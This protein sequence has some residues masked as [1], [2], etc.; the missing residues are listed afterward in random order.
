MQS[1]K[2]QV[3]AYFFVVGRLFSA[4][5]HGRP[6]ILET[7]NRRFSTAT[8]LGALVAG[9]LVA[10]FGILGLYLPGT[11]TSWQQPGAI[12]VDK[13]TGARYL[14]LNGRLRP[15]LNYT[16]AR[17]AAGSNAPGTIVQVSA[18]SLAGV[19][20]GTPIGI[21]GAPDSVPAASRLDAGPWTVCVSPPDVTGS[22]TETLLLGGPAGGP[23]PTDQGILVSTSDGSEYLLWLGKRYRLADHT[24]VDALGLNAVTPF[25]APASWLNPIPSGP[26]I[27]VP[28]VGALGS[29]GPVI[30][31]RQSLVGQLY[32]IWNPALR[33]NQVFVVRADGLAE[34]NPTAEALLLA[35]PGTQRAYPG[36]SVAPIQVTQGALAGVPASAGGDLMG[37]PAPLP[38]ML[39]RSLSDA[40]LPCVRY[41]P[42]ANGETGT[43][44][45]TLPGRAVAAAAS[46]VG[47]HVAGRTVDQVAIPAGSGVLV[48]DSPTAGATVT[49]E[50]LV[51]DFGVKYPLAD[52]S[53]TSTLGYP[54]GS[55]VAVPNQLLAMLPTGPVLSF[56]A[57]LAEQPPGAP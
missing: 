39:N 56:P 13:G 12:I 17:L 23:A 32:Q 29:P 6:D 22:A 38:A 52:S 45:L 2:D 24:V 9:L 42:S 50:Y 19:P 47:R 18:N 3:Q 20:V 41:S 5:T 30:N 14:Y 49:A 26:D 48:H 33:G 4:L 57:A 36:G 43:V 46:P 28:D 34:V 54:E 11:N 37:Y 35:A 10:I 40:L 21:P 7:P 31:A 1:R 53:V 44:F 27:V 15:V 8:V 55:A 16:S 25:P 51:T